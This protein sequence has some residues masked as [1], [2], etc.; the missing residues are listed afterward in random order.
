VKRFDNVCDDIPTWELVWTTKKGRTRHL[1]Y[2][3]EPSHPQQALVV[4]KSFLKESDVPAGSNGLALVDE[5][6]G[7]RAWINLH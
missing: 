4:R 7:E 5:N 2:L 1:E 3:S 6:G